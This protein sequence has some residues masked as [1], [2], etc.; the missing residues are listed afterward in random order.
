MLTIPQADILNYALTLEHLEYT[1]Y[2]ETLANYTE[3]MFAAAGFDSTFYMNL[4][5]VEYDEM[6]HVNFLTAGLMGKSATL[7]LP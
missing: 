5:E 3:A 4:M 2:K 1:F 7:L 6:T